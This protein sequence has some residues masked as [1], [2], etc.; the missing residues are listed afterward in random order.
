MDVDR[1]KGLFIPLIAAMSLFGCNL[2]YNMLYYPGTGVPAAAELAARRIQF[3]PSGQTGY[4]G[5]IGA[6]GTGKGT[7]IV[8]HGNA[9]TAADRTYYTDALGALGYRVILAEYPRYGLR[10]GSLGE[11]AFVADA[12]STVRLALQTYGEPLFLLGESLGCA[13][14]AAVSRDDS[15]KIAGLLLITPWDTLAAVS[16]SHFPWL[17]VRLFLKD[18]YDSQE[19]LRSFSGRVAVVAAER[20]EIVPLK[21]ARSLYQSLPEAKKFWLIEGAGHN[22]WLDGIDAA[23]WREWM[24]FVAG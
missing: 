22:D 23:R 21:H 3:W 20:D 7:V 2:Q 16:Q 18:R 14:A 15:L 9:G 19:N 24:Q 12:R 6:A 10:E 5:F 1:G 4:R 11:K 17:P 13:V 8:F